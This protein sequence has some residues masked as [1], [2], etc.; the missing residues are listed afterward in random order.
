MGKGGELIESTVSH[1]LSRPLPCFPLSAN[2]PF[3]FSLKA[4]L[5]CRSLS[6]AKAA[7]GWQGELSGERAWGFRA[8]GHPSW[9]PLRAESL[10][11]PFFDG[12]G[13]E[14]ERPQDRLGSD[15]GVESQ[16]DVGG[17]SGL[18]VGCVGSAFDQWTMS[19]HTLNLS[20]L[21]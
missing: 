13:L 5:D 11:P 17:R 14:V 9:H 20:T 10:A 6:L 18:L 4:A 1:A 16:S 12:G 19:S 3:F 21:L 8:A 7:A 2:W 15:S